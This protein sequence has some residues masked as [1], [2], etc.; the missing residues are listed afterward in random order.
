MANLT[1]AQCTR[2][3]HIIEH[4]ALLEAEYQQAGSDE[5]KA[6]V[7]EQKAEADSALAEQ[8]GV[9]LPMILSIKRHLS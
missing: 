3:A 8:F 5:A 2:L 6:L 7:Q 1:K 4:I 9:Y